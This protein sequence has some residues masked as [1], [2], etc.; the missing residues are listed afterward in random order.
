MEQHCKECGVKVVTGVVS[1]CMRWVWFSWVVMRN[2]EE[3]ELD[4]YM[5]SFMS[6]RKRK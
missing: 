2:L 5:F 1:R 6:D 3:H 4:F